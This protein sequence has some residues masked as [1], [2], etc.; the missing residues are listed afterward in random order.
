MLTKQA[1]IK[2]LRVNS[3]R[4]TNTFYSNVLKETETI[5]ENDV[6]NFSYI[7]IKITL[8]QVFK[9]NHSCVRLLYILSKSRRLNAL[10]T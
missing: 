5:N 1:A 3:V 2:T 9:V 8:E 10:F 4:K 6:I 7:C